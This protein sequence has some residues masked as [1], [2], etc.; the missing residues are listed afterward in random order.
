MRSPMAMIPLPPTPLPSAQHPPPSARPAPASMP[1]A[2]QRLWMFAAPLLVATPLLMPSRACAADLFSLG[3]RLDADVKSLRSPAS[4]ASAVNAEIFPILAARETVNKLLEDEETF[5]TMVTIGLPTGSLQM[6]SIPTR[7]GSLT[8]L[9]LL[10][11][12][13][14]LWACC[15]C[16]LVPTAPSAAAHH[17]I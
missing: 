8:W 6:V 1:G 3:N 17:I 13:S 16:M 11:C 15:I 14:D 12:S 10:A 9:P 7:F 2:R 5:R 4:G